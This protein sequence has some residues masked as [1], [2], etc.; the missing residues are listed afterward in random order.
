MAI[1]LTWDTI[2][3][4][5]RYKVYRSD[6]K[7]DISTLPDTPLVTMNKH[8][9]EFVDDLVDDDQVWYYLV[10]AEKVSGDSVSNFLIAS[11]STEYQKTY[12]GAGPKFIKRGDDQS[13]FFGDVPS[14]EFITYNEL[15]NALSNR[16]V[17]VGI[18]PHLRPHTTGR[19]TDM[20]WMKFVHKGKVIY[21]PK[22]AVYGKVRTPNPDNKFSLYYDQ[23][24][25]VGV[26]QDGTVSFNRTNIGTSRTYLS[27]AAVGSNEAIFYGGAQTDHNRRLT[28]LNSAGSLTG[29]TIVGTGMLYTSSTSIANIGFF[30]GGTTPT[31]TYSNTLTR[32]ASGGVLSSE[33]VITGGYGQRYGGGATADHIG[34][35]YGGY[36]G[37]WTHRLTR[38]D[39]NGTSLGNHIGV[40]SVPTAPGGAGIGSRAIFYGQS[41]RA[42]VLNSDGSYVTLGPLVG[43]SRTYL[44]GTGMS[45]A[46][47]FYGSSLITRLNTAGGSLSADQSI[48]GNGISNIAG[49]AALNSLSSANYVYTVDYSTLYR[50]GAVFGTGDEGVVPPGHDPVDQDLTVTKDGLSYRVR[51]MKLTD[52][53]LT[54]PL[55]LVEIG[56]RPY[57]DPDN[58]LKYSEYAETIDKRLIASG[59]ASYQGELRRAEFADEVPGGTTY[60]DRYESDDLVADR[61]GMDT[62][63][64]Y[65]V[66]HTRP[67]G[68]LESVGV[69]SVFNSNISAFLGGSRVFVNEDWYYI[70]RNDPDKLGFYWYPVLELINE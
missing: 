20:G 28:R 63:V 41:R 40:G 66:V 35:F 50:L 42:T 68:S 54:E 13:G 5:D 1:S 16:A 10:I 11:Y 17:Q 48:A 58:I 36:A 38:V 7:M 26:T 34:L 45:G 39:V 30:Y 44:T 21:V 43:S 62:A 55:D 3:T 33:A 69:T 49:G 15:Y 9:N 27:G 56:T 61:Q 46:A 6:S 47:H 18:E 60:S 19:R 51:L 8:Q 23:R 31:E 59:G 25:S 65:Q 52:L 32:I 22:G 24:R 12:G 37:S 57:L 29:E 14:N 67:N 64:G 2:P 70:N 4:V 53:D